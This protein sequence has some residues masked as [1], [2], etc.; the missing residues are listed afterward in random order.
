[1]GGG[2]GCS[3][4][5]DDADGIVG[6]GSDIDTVARIAKEMT[7]ASRVSNDKRSRGRERQIVASKNR[8]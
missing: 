5:K 3:I 2:N 4:W 7:R 1:M 6:A 8:F